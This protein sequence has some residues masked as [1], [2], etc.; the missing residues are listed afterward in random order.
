MKRQYN[1]GR[2]VVTECQSP[3]DDVSTA[4]KKDTSKAAKA[5]LDIRPDA[6]DKVLKGE[7]VVKKGRF[8]VFTCCRSAVKS[9]GEEDTELL[10]AGDSA[11][12]VWPGAAMLDHCEPL[13]LLIIEN[14]DMQP[15]HSTPINVGD[16]TPIGDQGPQHV[17]DTFSNSSWDSA[18]SFT[19]SCL[20]GK[21]PR[22]RVRFSD[23][24]VPL[25]SMPAAAAA[26]AS[27]TSSTASTSISQLSYGS[28]YS[29]PRSVS[30][31]AV[32]PVV[33]S[34]KRGRFA[35]EEAFLRCPVT[36]VARTI[37]C[38]SNAMGPSSC[39]SDA[40]HPSSM[41]AVAGMNSVSP[42]GASG[43]RHQPGAG[44]ASDAWGVDEDGD[45]I[46]DL[47]PCRRPATVSYFRRGRFLVQ[48]VV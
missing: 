15:A 18:S 27:P 39:R 22:G 33:R 32:G 6:A 35:V 28:R 41:V 16:C 47:P 23:S 25:G 43:A 30:E 7:R 38:P 48:T 5:P 2:F 17:L 20:E 4:G 3:R 26:A 11:K 21:T 45:G 37:S 14:D 8:K 13:N 19:S 42:T 29:G 34:Y 46:A 9:F 31:M 12:G 40:H 44:H 36:N 24:G 10:N 1:K